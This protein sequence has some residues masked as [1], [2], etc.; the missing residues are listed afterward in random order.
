VDAAT[1]K[2]FAAARRHL[3]AN[4]AA[5]ATALLQR[6]GASA[7]AAAPEKKPHPHDDATI[8]A[9]LRATRPAEIT[10]AAN[11]T[12]YPYF[13]FLP[14]TVGT[15]NPVTQ[16]TVTFATKCF[17]SI[18]VTTSFADATRDTIAVSVTAGNQIGFLCSDEISVVTVG[19]T[20]FVSLSRSGET[21]NKTWPLHNASLT[22]AE[23]WDL[24]AVGSRVLKWPKPLLFLVGDLLDTATLLLGFAEKPLTQPT[25]DANLR[26][27]QTY[28]EFDK[29]RMGPTTQVRAGGNAVAAGLNE[30]YIESGDAFIVLRQDGL[31]PLIA[32][33]EGF[34][35]GHSVIAVRDPTDPVFNVLHVCESTALDAYWPRNGIQC[36]PY[37]QW[38]AQAEA[39][40]FNV[41]LAPL[42]PTHRAAFDTKKAI[43]FFK[44]IE[45]N[46]YG[47]AN[48]LMGWL[49]TRSEN[50][51]CLPPD[52]TQCLDAGV[53][54][55]IFRVIDTFM[56]DASENLVRQAFNHRAGTV[57]LPFLD[58]LYTAATRQTGGATRGFLDLMTMVEQ[59]SWVYNMS[60]NN[61][62]VPGPA[63]HMAP[64]MVCNVFVCHMW[65]AGGVF[66]PIN[67]QLNC[68]E[69]T[70]YDTY[71][72]KVF[73]DAKTG[74][75]RPQICRDTDPE[76][77]LCQLIGP[78]TLYP[79]PDFNTR[80]MSPFFGS[81]CPSKGPSYERPQGC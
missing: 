58:V 1:A 77:T 81:H 15:A 9:A 61:T 13:A 69:L 60:R 64:C 55:I 74:A 34:E 44:S 63:Y 21:A 11:A 38:I 80:P 78:V 75:G 17:D 8:V 20:D 54:E 26:W 68:G 53:G 2:W 14:S 47:F 19:H 42:S 49:D 43:A 32:W 29:A 4:D 36:T 45:G 33:A 65:K 22:P 48:M 35:A 51:P 28:V 41:L 16:N 6:N 62:L 52:F 70:L 39:A 23:R 73:D 76:N 37:R 50:F 31:D 12:T 30:S 40:Q 18:S 7:K 59:D 67:N 57:G 3:Q 56:G 46:D 27:L 66:A 79:K 10:A 24:T 25:F 72:L 5:A 71:A